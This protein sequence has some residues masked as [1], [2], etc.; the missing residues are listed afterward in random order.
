MHQPSP[1]V[2]AVL[3]RLLS[4]PPQDPELL[5]QRVEAH[6]DH[7]LLHQH[8][9]TD[10]ALARALA[11][12]CKALLAGWDR[13]DDDGKRHA[14][15]ACLYFAEAQDA[16]D[17]LDLIGFEDDAE[18]VVWVAEQL[19]RGEVAAQVRKTWR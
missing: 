4:V 1:E 5:R 18:A 11:K 8:A 16:E 2:R 13:L 6:L 15:A 10:V 19:G 14:Q 9:D 17:D 7:V 3:A 12:A